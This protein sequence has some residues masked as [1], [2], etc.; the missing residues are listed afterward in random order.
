MARKDRGRGLPERLQAAVAAGDN[1]VARAEARRVLGD[2]GADEAD[3]AEA[4]RLLRSLA[5]E[6]AAAIC[7]AL[8]VA[9]ALAIAGWV[10]T[11][12]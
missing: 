6:R 12:G 5:P 3:R 10:L 11:R 4:A 2:A 1:G 7:G 8:G 9:T